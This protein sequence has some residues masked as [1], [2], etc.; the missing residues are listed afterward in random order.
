MSELWL[1]WLGSRDMRARR[2]LRQADSARDG[3]DW[4]RAAEHYAA[5]LGLRPADG[6]IRVQLGH[7]LKESGRLSEAE[8]AYR[9]AA[10]L[11]PDDADV[12]LHLGHLLKSLG[13]AAD[14]A[15][16]FAECHAVL[17]R[18]PAH[19]DGRTIRA[20]LEDATRLLGRDIG[21]QAR[22][23][24]NW[25]LAAQ[26]YR[27]YLE[28]ES[29][30]SAMWVQLGNVSKEARQFGPAEAAYRRAMEINPSQPES[31]FQLGHLLKVLDRREE[32]Q[33]AFRR[34]VE[35]GGGPE[36]QRE[37]SALAA[38]G[39]AGRATT[40]VSD[41]G[42]T[43]YTPEPA[44]KSQ[45]P[46]SPTVEALRHLLDAQAARDQRS[47]EIASSFY[48]FYLECEPFDAA[49]WLEYATVLRESGRYRR[50]Y[51]A[52]MRAAAQGLV[53]AA[54]KQEQVRLLRH[55][56]RHRQAEALLKTL[57]LHNEPSADDLEII[58]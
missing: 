31:F 56:R 47:W 8:A 53:S 22:D 42:A 4:V 12:R 5:Y 40:A 57:R 2:K 11:M 34:A 13:R 43:A 49:V 52:S 48:G 35:L 23:A 24:G 50:A 54:L 19:P 33:D 28:A 45:T 1:G 30:D 41:H 14:A 27:A 17:D 10:I 9:A 37:F 20:A 25:L 46:S 29:L 15:D 44:R 36:A 32:A 55:L 51:D 18:I 16:V 39:P 58:K 38:W 6:G 3:R 26:H 7:A 21:D